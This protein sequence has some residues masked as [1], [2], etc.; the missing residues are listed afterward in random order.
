[1]SRQSATVT[2][3]G[4]ITLPKEV[5]RQLNLQE[6]DRV[7]FV[8]EGARMVIGRA[9][10]RRTHSRSTSAPSQRFETN[11]RSHPGSPA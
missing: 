1:M 11:V 2:S 10:E 3:K 6:G 8:N 9:K 4:H 5:R 7:E